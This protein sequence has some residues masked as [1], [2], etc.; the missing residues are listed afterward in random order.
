M[1]LIDDKKAISAI[2]NYQK[3]IDNLYKLLVSIENINYETARKTILEQQ[4][5]TRSQKFRKWEIMDAIK[6][7]RERNIPALNITTSDISASDIPALNIT[8]S[9][10]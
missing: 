4:M 10:K 1:K 2:K 6:I 9:G 5:R 8:A 3:K 7:I